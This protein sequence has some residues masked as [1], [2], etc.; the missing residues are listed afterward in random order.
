M[1]LMV[2]MDMPCTARKRVCAKNKKEWVSQSRSPFNMGLN[3][4][5]LNN[6][7]LNQTFI[8]KGRS[9]K[10]YLERFIAIVK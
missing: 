6:W 10:E 7:N 1:S 4:I 2:Q 9:S 3:E 5:Y 8:F